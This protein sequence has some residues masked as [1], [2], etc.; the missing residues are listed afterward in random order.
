MF[1]AKHILEGWFEGPGWFPWFPRQNNTWFPLVS[2]NYLVSLKFS[3]LSL[4]CPWF[5]VV[6]P[7]FSLVFHWFSV[8]FHWFSVVFHW[9]SVVF[10]WLS[11]VFQVFCDFPWFLVVFCCFLWIFPC[12]L[13]VSLGFPW[14]PLQNHLVSLSLGVPWRAMGLAKDLLQRPLGEGLGSFAGASR[15]TF[16]REVLWK[17]PEAPPG[18]P[19]TWLLLG[20]CSPFLLAVV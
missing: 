16:P 8:V 7:W 5:S 19:A 10:P 20:T 4:V 18:P 9:F 2:F 1:G 3:W 11:V 17:N 13:L 6:F 14:F 12:F 15:R